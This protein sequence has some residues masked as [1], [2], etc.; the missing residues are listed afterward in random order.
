MKRY[1][2][3]IVLILILI[4][5]IGTYYGT[6]AA[7]VANLPRYEFKTIEGNEKE[8]KPVILD[9]VYKKDGLYEPLTFEGNQL[10]YKRENSYVENLN[11][12]YVEIEKLLKKYKPFMRGKHDREAL[13]EDGDFLAYASVTNHY[14]NEKYSATFEVSLLEKKNK[15]EFS[16]ELDVPEQEKIS[17]S[18]ILDVQLIDSKL[19]V[20]ANNQI[21]SQ[22]QIEEIHVYVIDLANNKVIN[23]ELILSETTNDISLEIEYPYN[24]KTIGE[25]HVFLYSV[26]KG[27][28]SESGEFVPKETVLNKYDFETGKVE[29][30]TVPKKFV[31]VDND[32]FY[33]TNNI[34]FYEVRDHRVHMT[35][36]DLSSQTILGE[37]SFDLVNDNN[38]FQFLIKNERVY[39]LAE[40]D[41]HHET[42]ANNSVSILIA[43][44]E[45][46]N[47]LY[48]GET[49]VKS[50]NEKSVENDGLS[51]HDLQVNEIN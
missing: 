27:H 46:G 21:D 35:T 42:K 18:R 12:Y 38:N 48:K 8:L 44:L 1:I 23:D 28:Y 15:E 17:Y 26:A 5:S 6:Q 11:G 29:T 40:N 4:G 3:S 13:Y 34:Y 20:V 30:I 49:K 32:I 7:S 22:D 41:Y 47:T 31:N 2:S 24:T 37:K 51:I 19:Q 25:S 50:K 43:D 10:T 36:F 16:F 39:I 45:T 9:G 33:D 14:R